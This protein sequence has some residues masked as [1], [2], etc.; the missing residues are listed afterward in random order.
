MPRFQIC[1]NFR[2]N[3]CEE[4]SDDTTALNLQNQLNTNIPVF[5]PCESAAR[6]EKVT[7]NEYEKDKED[8]KDFE[9][10]LTKLLSQL[11]GNK[12]ITNLGSTNH[13]P[14]LVLEKVLRLAGTTVASE[15]DLCSENCKVRPTCF[16]LLV[17]VATK[18]KPSICN[19]K[20]SAGPHF[21]TF[22]I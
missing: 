7:K 1:I 21:F 18:H 8:L 16:A 22:L 10:R 11:L 13:S 5:C 17:L 4:D 15:D 19:S 9:L 12:K 20:L 14:I 6:L 3:T 2:N